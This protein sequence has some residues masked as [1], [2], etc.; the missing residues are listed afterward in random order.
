VPAN[1][2]AKLAAQGADVRV[3][4]ALA[5]T[6]ARIMSANQDIRGL[7]DLEGRTLYLTG[8]GTTTECDLRMLLDAAD[9][10]GQV[11]LVFC[12]SSEDAIAAVDLD[13]QAA[14]LL[15]EPYASYVR[16]TRKSL[17]VVVDV[18]DVWK[19]LV[20]VCGV[21]LTG[22]IVARTGLIEEHPEDVAAFLRDLEVARQ[23][24]EEP[25]ALAQLLLENDMVED[26]DVG[27]RVEDR[28][29]LSLVYGADLKER[30]AP[31]YHQLLALNPELVAEAEPTDDF[32]Y[33]G[34]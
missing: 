32:Y 27:S 22:V 25:E 13:E 26:A 24:V 19:G 33:A 7:G 18:A 5:P 8:E 9:L 10:E 34:A 1:T 28:I 4:A 16:S 3:V 21:P 15:E 30:L 12:N 11:D 2:A 23:I 20:D 29:D 17:R 6:S 31:Y 14:C